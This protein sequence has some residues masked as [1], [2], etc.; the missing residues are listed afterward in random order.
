[1]RWQ[2]LDE[3]LTL[4][5]TWSEGYR[6]PSLEELFSAPVSTLQGTRDPL[7]NGLFE[8][9]TNTLIQSNKNLQPED[10]R[11]FSAGFVYTPKYV[12]GLTM[13]VDF[14]DTERTGI[15]AV[16]LAQQV[17]DRAVSGTL[18]PGEAVERDPTTNQ[19]SR[20]LLSNQN[21]G[22]QEARGYDFTL[23]YQRQTPWGTFTWLT[24]ATYLDEFLFPQ[25][26]EG[27]FGP[28]PGNLAGR[29]TDPATSNEGWY[30]W[31]GTSQ[32]DWNWNHFD[33][34]GTV[35]YI[36]G[37]HEFEGDGVTQHWVDATW[38]FDIQASYDF[39]GLVPVESKPVPGYSKDAKDVARG[40]EPS[41]KETAPAQTA[42]YGVSAWRRFLFDGTIITVGV[43]QS[44]RSG[45]AGGIRR[46]GKRSELSRLHLRCYEPV[47][48]RAPDEEVLTQFQRK[49]S[50]SRVNV[51]G[52][53]P[54]RV[55]SGF[56]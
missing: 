5:V 39:T 28:N 37:F 53:T 4:R 14:W 43:Q 40:K 54:S 13:S 23:Q 21:L 22:S 44:I 38:R 46:R 20:I 41:I 8:P 17:V 45:S 50:E 31:K 25:F 48:V 36:D 1:M 34:I 19:I 42:N 18:L 47:L 2:P 11:S 30:K 35:R 15:V 9:E 12:P 10:S 24:Q 33:I 55:R 16:P 51:G 7:F 6:Q 26:I 29:T 49:P 3:Q 32:L 27:E 56:V 52:I